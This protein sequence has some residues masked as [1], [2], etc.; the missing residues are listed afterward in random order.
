MKEIYAQ[1]KYY[2]IYNVKGYY[3]ASL[4][5]FLAIAIYF[6]YQFDFEN[7]VLR[8]R[9]RTEN[10]TFFVIAYYSIPYLYAFV[11]YALFY[12]A[13]HIFR[14]WKFWLPVLTAIA[15]LT[16][17]ES[18]Y[19]HLAWIEQNVARPENMNFL[20]ACVQNFVSAFL[21]FSPLFLYWFFVDRKKMPLYGF[22]P[23]AFNA[24]PYVIML[25]CMIPLLVAASF[26]EGFK[27]NYPVYNDFGFSK[28][29]NIPQWISVLFFEFFYGLDF[30][31]VEFLFRGFMIIALIDVLGIDSILP[32]A[33]LYCV[34][35]FGK[36]MGEAISAFF[37]ATILGVL[38]YNSR[39]IYGG[40]LIHIGVAFM[41][42]LL[43]F[44]Q[45]CD[46]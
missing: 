9:E 41:M 4:G 5:A 43:A 25:A 38:A 8:V 40:I 22:A 7:S 3:L 2:W 33:T 10:Y 15:S 27:E 17:D 35:H 46:F 12:N 28:L 6:N 30:I 39:S 34:Y 1:L 18:F 19:W 13:W 37:G 20:F 44:L 26:T 32:M 31:M 24:K 11:M 36:P 42:E 45:K 29:N 14:Q 23:K 21:Y 16:L